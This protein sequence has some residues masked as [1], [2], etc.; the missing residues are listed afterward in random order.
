[1][2]ILFPHKVI[3]LS[4][5]EY[6]SLKLKIYDQIDKKEWDDIIFPP[7][8]L[9]KKSLFSEEIRS[10]LLLNK[11]Y[12]DNTERTV[13][14]LFGPR[15]YLEEAKQYKSWERLRYDINKGNIKDLNNSSFPLFIHYMDDYIYN[16]GQKSKFDNAKFLIER[17]ANINI[18][19][20]KGRSFLYNFINKYKS[21]T[22]HFIGLRV[23]IDFIEFLLENGADPLL[24]DKD[25][26]S[27]YS[28]LIK[29]VSKRNYIYI[30]KDRI[31]ELLNSIYDELNLYYHR[32]NDENNDE[33]NTVRLC[34]IFYSFMF[35]YH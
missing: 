14:R 19:D 27:P 1:M 22:A 26:N 3:Y 33:N 10:V 8:A 24:G 20:D 4:D 21:N 29:E 30:S 2:N 31:K 35:G 12:D 25:G 7:Y 32:N 17:G 5:D 16:I 28:I 18:Q 6:K 15:D 23:Y 9:Y 11:P 34:E 13:V